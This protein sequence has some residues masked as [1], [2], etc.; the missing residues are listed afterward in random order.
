MEVIHNSEDGGVAGGS[1]T[2]FQVK[3]LFLYTGE[4][5]EGEVLLL[6]ALV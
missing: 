4:M 1:E 2:S 6:T 3:S 5:V